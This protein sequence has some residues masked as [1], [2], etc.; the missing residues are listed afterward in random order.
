M[1]TSERLERLR[2]AYQQ[3]LAH[4]LSSYENWEASVLGLELPEENT[5]WLLEYYKVVF[6]KQAPSKE[7]LQAMID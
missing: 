5:V 3:R 1:L 7:F 4:A 2:D 6:L